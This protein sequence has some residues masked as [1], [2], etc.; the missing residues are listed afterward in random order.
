MNIEMISKEEN[1]LSRL[2]L[3]DEDPGNDP[4]APSLR[5]DAFGIDV[6]DNWN[7]REQDAERFAQGHCQWASSD[8]RIF[9]PTGKTQD[10]LIPGVYEAKSN[11]TIGLYLEK[12]P[13]RTE[14]LVRFP[15]SNSDLVVGE[16]QKFWEKEEEYKKYGITYK[17]GI[18]LW[19]PPGSGKSCTI[20]LIMED[21]VKREGIILRFDD[22]DLFLEGMRAV[23]KIQPTTPVVV[24]MEDIDS[25]I[26][27]YSESEVLNILDGVNNVEKTVFLATT[28][29]PD[30]LGK[31]IVNRPSRFDKRFK[32]GYPS[33][34]ARKVFFE[35]L[36]KG[37]A[38]EIDLNKW[39]ED[40][41][42]F[43]VAHLQE[44]FTAVVI[45]GDKYEE[46]LETLQSM[47]EKIDEKDAPL[48]FGGIPPKQ[49]RRV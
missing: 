19:G 33:D 14:D 34:E 28:N 36:L 37:H 38:T 12:I 27:S 39:V 22:P 25:I 40:T 35:H 9:V 48:G 24:I 32:I 45:L 23:R 47:Q 46:A 26:A 29:Y 30:K 3:G 20:R 5:N 41:D 13:V 16:I 21:V 42:E 2:L 10:K 49:T 31:R 44:L 8:G 18:L 4:F 7:K 15:D 43:S 6:E 11:P 17:R 1:E